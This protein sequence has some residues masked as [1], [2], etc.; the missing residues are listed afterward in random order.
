MTG[1]LVVP[2][3]QQL[4][5]LADTQSLSDVL[6]GAS[7]VVKPLLALVI[8]PPR[9]ARSLLCLLYTSPSPRDRG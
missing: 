1:N 5:L 2:E 3:A 7:D 6:D 8:G 9:V 4:D